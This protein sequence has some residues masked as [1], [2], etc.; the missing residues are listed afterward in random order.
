M[1]KKDVAT[2][3]STLTENS[4]QLTR[5]HLK[6][7]Y[8]ILIA[9]GQYPRCPW[10]NEYIYN[11]NDFTWDHITPKSEGGCD[12]LSNLQPMHKSCNNEKK[13]N[14]L[15]QADYQYDIYSELENTITS[16]RVTTVCKKQ[17]NNTNQKHKKERYNNNKRR[18]G[19]HR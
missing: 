7:I 2:L 4:D 11:I 14:L 13:E 8:A 1:T 16:V 15:Y 3:L 6:K 5:K 17:P 18:S 9:S 19:K 12:D 10:C